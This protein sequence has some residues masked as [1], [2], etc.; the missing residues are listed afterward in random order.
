MAL[1]SLG[2]S[3][4]SEADGAGEADE[5]EGS[6]PAVVI[7]NRVC[8]ADE[9]LMYLGAFPEV[10]R[11]ELDRTRMI[12][13]GGLI[14]NN[15]FD[16]RVYT[17]DQ[18]SLALK[19][20]VITGDFLL[21][22][23]GELSF[24]NFGLT[25]TSE[26]YSRIVSASRAFSYLVDA[27][28]IVVWNPSTMAVEREIPM[29]PELVR[30]GIPA[31]A[32]PAVLAAGRVQWPVKWVDFDNMR[33]DSHAAVLCIDIESLEVELLEDPRAAV[34]SVLRVTEGGDTLVLSDNLAGWFNLFGEAAGTTPPE[35]VLRVQA[36]AG[37]DP[38]YRVDL[39]A[40]TGSPAVYGG[41]FLGDNAMLL[42]VW[43]PEVDPS[44][45]LT[46]ANDY[47]SGEE[48]VSMMMVD[49]ESG[50]AERF[51]LPPR[52]GAGSTGDPTEVDGKVYISVYR[53]GLDRT[54][55]FA[56]TP[57]GAEPAFSTQGDVLFMG[58]AR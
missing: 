2:A 37:F 11:A 43:D 23:A 4:C 34:T 57:A 31:N 27:Q 54:E 41:W 45:V 39:R 1:T 22:P 18:Q 14:Y 44:S 30:N 28:T 13:F 21:E 48:F 51:D 20:F 6:Q 9:C 52:G 38:E 15:S 3:G 24:A 36:G 12:E 17:Y 47:W 5:V 26:A 29:P 53:D 42:R 10:P 25:G 35:A 50:R 33:F 7:A 46:E 55:L 56:V 40:V 32:N 58:R 8:T 19:K 16:G 49:L